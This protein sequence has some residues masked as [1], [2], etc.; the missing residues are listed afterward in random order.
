LSTTVF[1]HIAPSQ[2]DAVVTEATTPR[3]EMHIELFARFNIC[4]FSCI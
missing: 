1:Y 4:F 3:I 2:M